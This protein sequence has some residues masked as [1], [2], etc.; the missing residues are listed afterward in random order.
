MGTELFTTL[1]ELGVYVILLAM[2]AAAGFRAITGIL[3]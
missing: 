2:L 1:F 3:E